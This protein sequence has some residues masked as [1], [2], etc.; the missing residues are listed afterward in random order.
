[1]SAEAVIELPETLNLKLTKDIKQASKKMTTEEARQMVRWYYDWQQQ[2]IRCSNQVV[3]AARAEQSSDCVSYLTDA[4]ETIENRMAG[5]LAQF[6]NASELGRWSQSH[7]GIG[8]VLTCGMLSNINISRCPYPGNLWSFAGLNPTRVWEKGQ[9]RP[10]N[11]DLKV[12]CW[13]TGQSFIKGCR[14]QERGKSRTFYGLMYILQKAHYQKLNDAG[15]Y[16]ERA[17]EILKARKFSDDT[18][19][20]KAYLAGTLPPAHI[21]AMAARWAV[22]M[23]LTH[24]WQQAWEIDNP[25]KAAPVA[26][27]LTQGTHSREVTRAHV[28][29]WE[30]GRMTDDELYKCLPTHLAS[31]SIR[32]ILEKPAAKDE[33]LPEEDVEE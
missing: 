1:M 21:S 14:R 10:W 4:I 8:P 24:Y 32:A 6:A 20:K 29:S 11:A 19:A 15:Q 27:I 23:W 22:K 26:W 5:M 13:K 31:L 16:R 2:R 30:E 33:E 3:A 18:N 9:R 7:W 12:I 17:A 28:R 25:G